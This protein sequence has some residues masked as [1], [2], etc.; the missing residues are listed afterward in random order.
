MSTLI[1]GPWSHVPFFFPRLQLP[2][3]LFPPRTEGGCLFL[4]CRL[5]GHLVTGL[6]H[7]SVGIQV[8][9]Q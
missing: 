9:P 2:P 7:L 8:A 3:Q 4:C 5:V 6:P 1:L